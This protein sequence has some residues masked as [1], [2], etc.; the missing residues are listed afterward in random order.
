MT[1]YTDDLSQF[2]ATREAHRWL[3]QSG[4]YGNVLE[5]AGRFDSKLEPE[6]NTS[7]AAHILNAVTVA[8]N[9]FVYET[10]DP[11]GGACGPPAGRP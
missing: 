7:L 3:V 11:D 10:W 9:T 1:D 5:H 2:E 6:Q 4:L 8:V